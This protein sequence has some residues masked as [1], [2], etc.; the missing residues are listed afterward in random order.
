M[1]TA[2]AAGTWAIRSGLRVAYI[3]TG[4]ALGLCWYVYP[5]ALYAVP[6]T[7]FLLVLYRPPVSRSEIV[8]WAHTLFAMVATVFPLFAQPEYWSSK[9][10]GTLA[11]D[12]RITADLGTLAHHLSSN[13]VYAFYSYVYAPEETHFVAISYVDAF[14]AVLVPIGLAVLI[15]GLRSRRIAWFVLLAFAGLLFLV[16]AS[17]DRPRPTATR[18]F[19]LLPWFTLLAALGL[20]WTQRQ[21]QSRDQR[22]RLA[23][24]AAGSF[25]VAL[26]MLNVV[27]AYVVGPSR[28]MQYENV[29]ATL[30][31]LGQYLSRTGLDHERRMVFVNDPATG[32]VPGIANLLRV[33]YVGISLAEWRVT[34]GTP[35]SARSLLIADDVLVIPGPRLSASDSLLYQQ[36]LQSSGR[37]RCSVRNSGGEEKLVV[38][39][40]LSMR[41]PCPDEEDVQRGPLAPPYLLLLGFLGV[42]LAGSVIAQ[43]PSEGRAAPDSTVAGAS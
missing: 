3:S 36:L 37:Q 15:W 27:H 33:Y 31:R 7:L 21:L 19:L 10:A 28:T 4:L 18:M 24:V 20:D 17:H 9:R 43:K 5:A 2:L 6:V 30:L 29:E 40:P 39:Y 42:G 1:A 32:H 38:W 34:A 35:E 12:P 41:V 16:G 23:L 25:F 22:P 13:L 14:T 11:N 8:R 26:V